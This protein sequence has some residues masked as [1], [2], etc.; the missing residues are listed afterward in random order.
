MLKV[1]PFQHE[2][3]ESFQEHSAAD[4][5]IGLTCI[6]YN[7]HTQLMVSSLLNHVEYSK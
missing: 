6:E 5:R 2:V 7:E 4:S 3:T 1:L